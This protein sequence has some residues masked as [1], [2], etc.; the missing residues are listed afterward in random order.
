MQ[1]KKDNKKVIILYKFY[2][3][4]ISFDSL[5][6]FRTSTFDIRSGRAP[7]SL[8]RKAHFTFP[9]PYPLPPLPDSQHDCLLNKGLPTRSIIPYA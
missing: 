5:L 3:I 6:C 1:T 4:S 7:K 8:G 9:P 2:F